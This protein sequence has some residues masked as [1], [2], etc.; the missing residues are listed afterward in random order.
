MPDHNQLTADLSFHLRTAL[1]G[2][3]HV[4]FELSVGNAI[5]LRQLDD[6]LDGISLLSLFGSFNLLFQLG[7]LGHQ[8]GEFAHLEFL[9]VLWIWT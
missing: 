2:T 7:L 3:G 5:G 6:L 8:L 4:R 9:K 1:T